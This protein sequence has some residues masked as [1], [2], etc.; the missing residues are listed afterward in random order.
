MARASQV[1]QEMALTGLAPVLTAPTVD[2]DIVDVDS[3][4]FLY[5]LN[6]S[7]APITV[8][9]RTPDTVQDLTVQERAVSVAAGAFQLIPLVMPAYKRPVGAVDAGRAYVDYSAVAS[10]TRGVISLP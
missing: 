10:V 9:V 7:G 5:V 8:T 6:S 2:G 1:S 4:T 3:R